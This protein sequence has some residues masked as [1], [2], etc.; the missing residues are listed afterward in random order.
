MCIVIVA[1]KFWV[2]SD[3]F[4]FAHNF[5]SIG[6][7]PLKC[8]GHVGDSLELLHTKGKN[9]NSSRSGARPELAEKCFKSPRLT[10]YAHWVGRGTAQ[11]AHLQEINFI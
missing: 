11:H 8:A 7:S 9:S 10:L 6:A 5:F 2:S 1:T 3:A 4:Y